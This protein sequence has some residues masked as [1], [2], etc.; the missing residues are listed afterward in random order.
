[1]AIL[2]RKDIEA[3]F[4]ALDRINAGQE[5]TAEQLDNAPVLSR[6]GVSADD[7]TRLVGTV[8]DHPIL[9]NQLITT[10]PVLYLAPDQTWCRTISRY[11]RLVNSV[12]DMLNEAMKKGKLK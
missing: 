11:Y 12:H 8:S 10:S 1:M 4:E 3:G 2:T 5:P 9:G 6:W 7:G